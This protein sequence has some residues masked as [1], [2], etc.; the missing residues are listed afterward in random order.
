MKQII[1]AAILSVSI[2]S[3]GVAQKKSKKN[4]ET[5][6][7]QTVTPD[8]TEVKPE[9]KA[10]L[11]PEQK[12]EPAFTTLSLREHFAKKR[13]VAA[14]WSDVDVVKDALYDLIVEDPNNDSVIFQLAYLYYDNQKYPSAILIG[15]D[16]LNR[17]PKNVQ[18]LELVADSYENLRI[19]DRA[20]QNYESLFLLTSNTSMLYKMAM[21]QFELKRYQETLTNIDILLS[22]PEADSLKVVMND[23]KNQQKEYP[24]RVAL[25][26]LKG[27]VYKAQGDKVNARK[28]FE[29][30]LKMAPDFQFAKQNLDGLNK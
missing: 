27:M 11:P 25:T 20:L 1:I 15:Q 5:E 7:Q 9:V 17:N 21:L 28:Y 2:V 18:V 13:A 3:V 10:E 24:I 29:S 4:K 14:R 30:A 19:Y 23:T 8:K 22:K 16:L 12:T 6:Q 26:N